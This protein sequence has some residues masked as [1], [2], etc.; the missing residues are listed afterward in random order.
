MEIGVLASL[1]AEGQ[2][3]RATAIIESAIARSF[4]TDN[5]PM[6][7]P[8]RAEVKR[9]FGIAISIFKVLRGDLEWSLS[10]I[11]DYLG[12]YLR[13]ELD[14]VSWKPDTRALWTPDPP[15]LVLPSGLHS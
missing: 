14:G 12:R 13:N 7:N 11:G 4:Q 3:P 2:I 5:P 8:V 15:A 9:R 10:R 6:R 1:L